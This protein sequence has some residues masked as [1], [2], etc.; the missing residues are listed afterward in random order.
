M[1]L[2]RITPREIQN[3]QFDFFIPRIMLQFKVIIVVPVWHVVL[4]LE[5]KRMLT[6][7][8]LHNY[9]NDQAT[10]GN[11]TPRRLID[12]TQCRHVE[13]MQQATSQGQE[14]NASLNEQ[15]SSADLPTLNLPRFN[16]ID[17]IDWL[18][19]SIDHRDVEEYERIDF[20]LKI[21]PKDQRIGEHRYTTLH[22]RRQRS[23]NSK[24][25][26]SRIFQSLKAPR[27]TRR[28]VRSLSNPSA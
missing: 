11:M 15:L 14:S 2:R 17:E 3:V 5:G 25:A 18:Q 6:I 27:L 19:R 23:F 13:G 8:D 12:Y 1:Y 26:S 28:A 20:Q 24:M 4:I 7:I 22:V 16:K 9:Y 21:V 10:R